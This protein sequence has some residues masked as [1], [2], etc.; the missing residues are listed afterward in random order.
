MDEAY[1]VHRSDRKCIRI[2]IG[3]P[4]RKGT[5]KAKAS[6]LRTTGVL[7]CIKLIPDLL[8]KRFIYIDDISDAF[9]AYLAASLVKFRDFVYWALLGDECPLL[10]SANRYGD[11][12]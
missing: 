5:W 11:Q 3:E 1:I 7:L 12:D 4:E 2:F 6:L 8:P 10:S 9:R